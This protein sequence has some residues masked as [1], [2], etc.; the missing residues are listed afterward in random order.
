MTKNIAVA[1]VLLASSV[2]AALAQPVVDKPGTYE[3]TLPGSA[4]RYTLVIPRAYR[5]GNPV[6]LVMAL[7]YG[8]RLTPFIGGGF[9]EQLVE[10]ALRDLGAI[11]VAPD[12]AAN[13][14]S[15]PIAERHVIELLAYIEA[16]YNVDPKRTLL[17]GYSMGAGGT[18]YLAPRHPE[19][20]ETAIAMAGRPQADSTQLDWRTPMY[21]IN[22]TADELIP[23]EPARAAVESLRE[24]GAPITMKTIDGVTHYEVPR[25][26]PHLKAAI[27]W[28]ENIWN[29]P[30]KE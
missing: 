18:W 28:I 1:L 20:F 23:I 30:A 16:N 2:S 26:R 7:H 8:G 3:L 19:L 17:I 11:M 24:R 12:S 9:L 21:A 13:D 25:Y 29:Q 4:R 10:P 5:A 14:W 27:P 22:S 15:N 6:P